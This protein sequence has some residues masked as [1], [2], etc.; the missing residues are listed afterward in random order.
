ML[1]LKKIAIMAK[2]QMSKIIGAIYN[3]VADARDFVIL[4]QGTLNLLE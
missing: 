1:L 2:G 4:C 3:I